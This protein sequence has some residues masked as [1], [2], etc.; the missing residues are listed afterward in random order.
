MVTRKDGN[1]SG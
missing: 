1:F